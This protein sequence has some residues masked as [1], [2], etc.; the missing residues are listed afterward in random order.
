MAQDIKNVIHVIFHKQDNWKIQLLQNWP[1]IIGKLHSKVRLEKINKDSL[2]LGVYDSCWLQELYLLSPILLRKINQKLENKSFKR[3]SFR[4]V[5]IKKSKTKE[6]FKKQETTSEKTTLT[7]KEQKTLEK[8]KDP[9]LKDSLKS[10]LL[11]CRRG[12]SL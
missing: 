6:A 5:Y 4:Q 2:V 1:S 8:I 3:L 12:Q 10:F 11:R 7:R 9:D